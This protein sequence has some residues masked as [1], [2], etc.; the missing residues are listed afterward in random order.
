MRRH[1]QELISALVE[2]RLE[3]ETEALTLVATS[4]T[5]RSEYEAQK[6]AYEALTAIPPAQLSD[7][8][9]AALRR[10]V[11]TELQAQP[12]P[13]SAKTPWY[14]RWSTAAAGL[15]VVVGIVTIT[16]LGGIGGQDASTVAFSET[17]SAAVLAP[18]R[19]VADEEG[20]DDGTAAPSAGAAAAEDLP[21]IPDPTLQ[22]FNLMSEE[23]RLNDP[24]LSG[25]SSLE[26]QAFA[27]DHA[28]CLTEAALEGY[29]T[30]SEFF[31]TTIEDY[32]TLET[33]YLAAVLIDQP[34]GPKTP[35]A[36]V[37]LSTCT[38]I[39]IDE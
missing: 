31:H 36:Y 37:V 6:L 17:T 22:A 26:L 30:V 2:G 29:E 38:V 1:E 9:S 21:V 27:T 25:I 24:R 18:E 4:E 33:A 23:L 39:Y 14:F 7:H 13:L 10:D 20:A 32:G 12:T 28:A 19:G 11:W 15:F 8:E 34:T 5:M 35:V 16:N 3:D